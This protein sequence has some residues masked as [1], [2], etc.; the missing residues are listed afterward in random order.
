MGRS[1]GAPGGSGINFDVAIVRPHD[2]VARLEQPCS[3][4]QFVLNR[5]Q[6]NP[7]YAPGQFTGQLTHL[8]GG[9]VRS[10]RSVIGAGE[11]SPGSTGLSSA[12]FGWYLLGWGGLVFVLVGGLDLGLA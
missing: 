11:D 10:E 4:V 1:C 3:G 8:N 2:R 12:E 6:S 7:K 5:A 9:D